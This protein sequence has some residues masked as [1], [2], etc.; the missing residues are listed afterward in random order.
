VLTLGSGGSLAG[1]LT[2][3]NKGTGTVQT[4]NYV[5]VG[6][7]STLQNA[8]T[9]AL[10]DGA[11]IAYPYDE[12][13]LVNDVGATISYAGGTQGAYIGVPFDNYG[14][15]SAAVGAR[16]GTLYIEAG[17]STNASDTGA[18][19]ASGGATIDMTGGNRVWGTGFTFTGP[20]QLEVSGG[21]VDVPGSV[22][23]PNLA[24]TGSGQLSGPGTVTVPGSGV[25][26]LGSGG[27]LTGG[28]TPI[29]KGT[30]TVQ[31]GNYVS[32]EGGST[33]QNAGTLTLA[34]GADIAFPY[35]EGQLINGAAGT[36]KYAGGTQGATIDVP[37][38]NYGKVN[39]SVGTRGGTLSIYTGNTAN[40]SDTG[41]YS[42]S[43]A[44]TINLAGGTRVL[45]PS[46][47]LTGPGALEVG[48][49]DVID[50]GAGN[51][52]SL[53]LQGGTMEITPQATGKL[54]SLVENSPATLQ[55]DVS[56]ATPQA[57]PAQLVITGQ[58]ALGGT[59]VLQPTPTF[60]PATG[61]VLHLFD[62]ASKSGAFSSVVTPPGNVQY[63]L[64]TGATA[65]TATA[66]DLNSSPH[67]RVPGA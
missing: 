55:F 14:T 22:S 23:V 21:V 25:L 36:I 37:F 19:A 4:G 34:D 6:G 29:N 54:A 39:A 42:A 24:V 10:A 43:N 27:S 33:L 30:G 7:G 28:L 13:Q 49:G 41:T 64:N 18:Y 16:G 44:A 48:G 17:N 15:V 50:S 47:Q 20:G 60:V 52:A 46:A 8:G 3:V 1:G 67:R 56:P 26:A 38:D 65:L 57:E 5:S 53:Q 62:Y 58:A 2:L 11:D 45:A 61:T 12:G 31:T 59:F 35:D 32:V 63:T 66:T 51:G 40:A 9:L